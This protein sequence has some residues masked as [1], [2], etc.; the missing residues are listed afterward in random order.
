M[1]CNSV[2]IPGTVSILFHI[3]IYIYIYISFKKLIYF[4]IKKKE[5]TKYY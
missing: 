1:V 3:Y 2:S 5:R 4:L